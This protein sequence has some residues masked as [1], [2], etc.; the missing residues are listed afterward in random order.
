[1]HMPNPIH[2]ALQQS[3]LR[4]L[5]CPVCRQLLE[6]DADAIRCNACGGRYPIVDGIPVLLAPGA[7]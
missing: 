3:D 5:A 1:L 4:W 2:L 6:L 7:Q